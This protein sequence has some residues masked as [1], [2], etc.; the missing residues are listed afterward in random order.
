MKEWRCLVLSPEGER[1]WRRVMARD[2]RQAA[3]MMTDEGLIPLDVRTGTLSIGEILN[4]PVQIGG[5]LRLSDQ[6]LILKQMSMLLRAG[7]PVDRSVD[8]LREQMPKKGHRHYLAEVLAR[9]RSGESLSLALD[10]RKVFPAYVTGVIGAAERSGNLERAF[11]MLSDRL[12]EL[13]D[14]RRELATSLAYPI[15]VLIAT[16]LALTIVVTIVIPQFEPLFAGEEAR[17]P[18]ITRYILTLS[19]ALRNHGLTILIMV[20]L[21]IIITYI[22]LQTM[23]FRQWFNRYRYYIPGM[24]V[25]DQYLAARFATILGTLLDNGVVVVRALPLARAALSSKRWQDYA[26]QV[27][28][29]LQEGQRIAQALAHGGL[30]PAAAV[31]LA[32]VGEHGGKLGEALTEAGRIMHASAKARIDRFVALANPV[33]IMLLGGLVASLVGGVMLGIFALGDFAG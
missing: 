22:W 3:G 21:A 31:R 33:S 17:L 10:C 25:R 19:Q 12:G 4:K 20:I 11:A 30:M 7:M 2:E 5:P 27:E 16:L 32:E 29:H 28:Q 26:K 24:H 9:V 6:A 8:L 1:D 13:A 23:S 15:A 14:A 18:A